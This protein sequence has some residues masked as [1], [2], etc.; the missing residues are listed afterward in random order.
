MIEDF[1]SKEQSEK[2]AELG[3]AYA[4]LCHAMQSGVA[5][6]MQ[7]V[8]AETQ[9]KHLRVG[10]NSAMVDSSA[11][12]YLLIRK[13]LITE[14]EYLEELCQFMKREVESYEKWLSD[15]YGKKVSLA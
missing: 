9:P 13:G 4:S 10:V 8:G 11:L 1:P 15:H 3:A 14:E 6:K 5:M 12:A 2:I 7:I